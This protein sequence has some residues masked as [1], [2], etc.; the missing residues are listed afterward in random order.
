MQKE[1]PRWGPCVHGPTE[2]HLQRGEFDWYASDAIFFALQWK[3]KRSEQLFI[4]LLHDPEDCTNA[5]RR[6]KNGNILRQQQ[7][8][9]RRV[10]WADITID[11]VQ[12]NC[13]QE[14][15]SY[16][17]RTSRSTVCR[18]IVSFLRKFP[19]GRC[20]GGDR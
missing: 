5:N 9:S 3:E 1:T 7:E 13:K 10:P 4:K 2:K 20:G 12:T 16:H 15:S 8:R 17:G 11:C 18:Q 19:P 6:E 14:I